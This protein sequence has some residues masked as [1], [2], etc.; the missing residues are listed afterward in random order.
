MIAL[1]YLLITKKANTVVMMPGAKSSEDLLRDS[2]AEE[3]GI[4]L[5]QKR[6]L[7]EFRASSDGRLTSFDGEYEP[8]IETVSGKILSVKKIPNENSK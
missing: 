4:H 7:E 3:S 8:Y 6:L 5:K 2:F 1:A